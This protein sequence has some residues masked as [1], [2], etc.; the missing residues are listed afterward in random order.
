MSQ[1]YRIALV[2]LGAAGAALAAELTQRG[3]GPLVG[4]DVD[5]AVMAAVRDQ[6]GIAYAGLFGENIAPIEPAGS[7]ASAASQAD[8]IVVSVTADRHAEAAARLAPALTDTHRILLH[9]GYV[10]GSRVFA[11]SL[12]A[13]NAAVLPP[14]AESINTLH[15][16]GCPCPG[17]VFIKGRKHWL[18]VSGYR[19]EMTGQIM[20]A[21]LP[22]LP[23]L[24]AGRSALETGLNNPNPV[25]HL[26][27]LIGNL[28]LLERDNGQIG[29]GILQFDE[30]RS[31]AVQRVCDAFERER[32]AVI[33]ALGLQ[34]LPIAEFS[35]RAYPEGARLNEGVPR[36]GPKLLPRFFAEDFPAGAV[37]LESVGKQCDVA[38]PVISSLI[39][40]GEAVTGRDF[41]LAGRTVE[42]LGED[43]IR[44]EVARAR[45]VGQRVG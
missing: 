28:G 30:L 7:A 40:I 13:A 31:P 27:C 44:S 32:V 19:P 26:P 21:F 15:L 14:V 25:G 37:P 24:V 29:M 4:Y 42:S 10:G 35:R 33:T 39:D 18:E 38:T 17:L 1:R 43:W 6:G 16:S 20:A 9:S 3:A 45:Q 8:L 34:P 41:R 5:P 36:F 22:W 2:G 11:T 23:G 12:M